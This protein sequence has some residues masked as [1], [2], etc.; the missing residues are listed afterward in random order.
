MSI[1]VT[2]PKMNPFMALSLYRRELSISQAL[3]SSRTGRMPV[4]SGF[5]FSSVCCFER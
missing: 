2:M 3:L 5:W 1:I 4:A